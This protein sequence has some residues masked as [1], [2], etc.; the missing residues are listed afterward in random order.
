[1]KPRLYERVALSGDFPEHDLR[2]GDVATLVD[3]V[4]HPSGGERGC[5]VEVFNAIG[6]SIKTVVIPESSLAALRAD[7]IMSVRPL[8]SSP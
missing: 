6:E 3:F 8:A 4:S 7:E 1:M 5:V 2:R